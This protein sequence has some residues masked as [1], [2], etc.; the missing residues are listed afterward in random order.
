MILANDILRPTLRTPFPGES[1]FWKCPKT[2]LIVP[3]SVQENIEWRTKL[4]RRAENDPIFQRDLMSACKV[5]Q[6][7]WINTFA[8]TYRQFE[9]NLETGERQDCI[10]PHVPFV[11]WEIQ[12][13][14]QELFE[15]CLKNA[16]DIL[17]DKSRDMGAS[18]CCIAFIHWLWLFRPE[19]QMLEMSRT[20]EYVDWPGN[21]K[22]LFQKHDYING[23]L[24]DWMRPDECLPEERF[25]TKKHLKNMHNNSCIDGESTTQYA[26]KGDRRLVGLL[27][28]FAACEEGEAMDTATRDACLIRIINS[29]VGGPGTAYSRIKNSGKTKVFIMPFH[30]HPE[31]GNGR[32]V[33]ETEQG[34]F[35]IRSPWFDVE[36]K[37]RSPKQIATEI[38]RQDI[39]SG[40]VF[41]TTHNIDK[42]VALFARDPISTWNINLK[43]SIAKDAIGD[44][45]RR[46]DYSSVVITKCSTGPLRVWTNLIMNRPDQSKSYIFGIDLGKG[47]GASNSV[48]SIKCKETGEKIAEWKSAV[49]PPYEMAYL[50]MALSIWCGGRKPHGLPFLKWEMNGPGWDFGRIVVKQFRY[51]YYYRNVVPGKIVDE[52]SESYGWHSGKQSK[53]ELLALY[54]R[55][56]AIGGYINHS[57]EGLEEAKIYIYFTD[58]GIGPAYLIEENISARKT[59][60]DIVI[61]DALTLDNSD[62][63]RGRI[64]DNDIIPENSAGYRLQ[65]M[66]NK[67]NRKQKSWRRPY[68]FTRSVN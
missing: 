31:K 39:Q 35:E 10:H 7:F 32:Y 25:R 54:D 66:I 24:P 14:L 44:I 52:K 37:I 26:A 50:V 17:I 4:L 20:V 3:K 60:G 5:S 45:V 36:E 59:H 62:I 19:S 33:K 16:K 57:K 41:F 11:T 22:A 13:E 53:Y 47:Q 46:K 27:D 40:D 12:N 34:K 43:S 55:M 8:W 65:Q 49:V 30:E 29:T 68:D 58:G 15:W 61:A 28:E 51:P 9:T 1:R 21:M 64:V 42:H 48:V 6:L 38:L 2:G 23:W 67:K 63:P 18:W 56:L